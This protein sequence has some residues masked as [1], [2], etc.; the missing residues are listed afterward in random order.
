M[1]LRVF[2][3]Y[4]RVLLWLAFVVAKSSPKNCIL[5]INS[6]CFHFEPALPYAGC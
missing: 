6:D 3:V 4:L 5:G 2:P 1:H